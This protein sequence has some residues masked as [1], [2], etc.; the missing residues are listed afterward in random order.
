[1]REELV[2]LREMLRVVLAQVGDGGIGGRGRI[3]L[4]GH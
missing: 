2:E 3:G 1:M 4:A